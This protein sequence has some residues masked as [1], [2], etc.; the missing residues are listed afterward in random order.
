MS[1]VLGACQPHHPHWGQ[2]WG[3]EKTTGKVGVCFLFRRP[4][5][6]D[7]SLLHV[8]P[9]RSFKP[10]RKWWLLCGSGCSE[11]VKRRQSFSLSLRTRNW[12]W[13]A[14]RNGECGDVVSR[15]CWLIDYSAQ[16]IVIMD[17]RV[18]MLCFIRCSIVVVGSN[19]QPVFT[20]CPPLCH[21]HHLDFI[22]IHKEET[23]MHK[24]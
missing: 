19:P 12:F 5:A 22:Y 23:K 21:F 6:R 2:Q 1:A 17:I 14:P 3:E 8:A 11:S 10:R 24:N 18:L 13:S 7:F 20:Y 16:F 15:H 9:L 4:E